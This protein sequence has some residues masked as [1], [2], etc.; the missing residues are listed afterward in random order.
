MEDKQAAV[1]PSP[2][3]FPALQTL[4]LHKVHPSTIKPGAMPCLRRLSLRSI[5]GF[6]ISQLYN[7]LSGADTISEIRLEYSNPAIDMRLAPDH[8]RSFLPLPPSASAPPLIL[9]VLSLAWIPVPFADLWRIFHFLR[10]PRLEWLSLGIHV[11][12]YSSRLIHR[13]DGV[14]FFAEGTNAGI[15]DDSVVT[16]DG[17]R[18]LNITYCGLHDPNPPEPRLDRLYFPTLQSLSLMSYELDRHPSSLPLPPFS[19]LFYDQA[20][21]KLTALE[22]RHFTLTFPHA[23]S[24]LE[25]MPSL[26]MLALHDCPGTGA[27][28][29]GLAA[30]SC[31]HGHDSRGSAWLCPGLDTLR[32]VGA[33]DLRIECLR[34][35]LAARAQAAVS[36]DRGISGDS[37][38]V[39][40]DVTNADAR[41]A[42][43][44]LHLGTDPR[45]SDVRQAR[46]ARVRFRRCA[47]VTEEGAMGLLELCGGPEKVKWTE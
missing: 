7:L 16:L 23:R 8:V 2:S 46:I 39:L 27:V 20:F 17:L 14:M 36:S 30:G 25:R 19:A 4:S 6:S 9:P 10:M 1:V 29:C 24:V 5:D 18:H 42:R 33:D 11:S 28:V 43:Q 41:S 47:Q 45:K 26:Q 37:R 32:L 40:G 38:G 13:L 12:R 22:L 44:W 31:E 3:R 15:P 35:V 34:R 21:E